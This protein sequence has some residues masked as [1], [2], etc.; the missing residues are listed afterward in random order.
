MQTDFKFKMEA[1]DENGSDNDSE[2]KRDV[3]WV[4]DENKENSKSFEENLEDQEEWEPHWPQDDP[5]FNRTEEYIS[6]E[7]VSTSSPS[8]HSNFAEASFQS[9]FREDEGL[10]CFVLFL[11]VHLKNINFMSSYLLCLQREWKEKNSRIRQ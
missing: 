3:F 2:K 11:F 7:N 6:S 8:L 9:S 10:F 4:F 5:A 1:H